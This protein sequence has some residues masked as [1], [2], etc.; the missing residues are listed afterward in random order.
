[1]KLRRDLLTVAMVVLTGS[2]FAQDSTA[3]KSEPTK[4]KP[5]SEVITNKAVSSFGLFAVHKVGD[6]YF[7]EMPDSLLGREL[8]FTTR[9]SKVATG[10]PA[11][12]GEVVNNI[13]VSFEKAEDNKLYVRAN[14][15]VAE[16]AQNQAIA[17]AVNNSTI[18]P[19]IM[20]MDVKARSKSNDGSV[21]DITDFIMKDNLVTGFSSEAK[22]SLRLS[23]VAADRSYFL[24]ANAY[25]Q[26]VEIKTVKTFSMGGAAPAPGEP[27]APTSPSAGVTM[28]M[29]NS[30][31]LLSKTPMNARYADPR[32]GY[33]TES[34]NVFSDAQQKVEVKNFIVRQRL[35]PKSEDLENYKKGVLVEPRNPIVYYVDPATPKQWRQYIIAGINDWNEAFKEAGFKNAIVGK[36]WPENDT[37]MDIDD[38]RWK[39]VRYFPSSNATAY[40]QRLY[41]PRSGEVLQTYIGWSH[42]NMQSLH[43]WYFIQA[44]AADP[45]GRS[46]KFS[47][48]LMGAL[49]RAEISKQVGYSLGLK[50]NLAASSSVPTEKLRDKAWVEANGI[51]PSILDY[52]HYNYV[53]QPSDKIGT[54][55]MVPRIGA[56]DKWAIKYGYT[57]TGISDFEAEKTKVQGWIAKAVNNNPSLRFQAE[58]NI[59]LNDPAD[60]SAQTEDLGD[61]VVLSSQYSLSNMKLLTANLLQWTKEDM[62]MYDNAAIA[63]DNMIDWW[64][65]LNRHVFSQVSGV[66]TSIKS[67]EQEG[68]VYTPISKATQKQAVAYLNREVFQTPTWLLNPTVLNK[69]AKPVKRDKVARFQE[70]AMYQI[71]N[72]NRLY[73][74]YT[75]AMRYSKDKVY[76]V[77]EL[78]TDIRTGVWSELKSPNAVISSNRRGIQK[79]WIENTCMLIRVS[80]T[81]PEAGSAAN[82]LSTTDIPAVVRAQATLVMQQCKTAAATSTDPLTQAHLKYAY[83]KLN[84]ALTGDSKK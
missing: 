84:K 8:L 56:Y 13:N 57:Y 73:R 36:E 71:M 75:Q 46:V 63:Y 23:A 44:A 79:S 82:D 43:D 58:T 51:T 9:F 72:P 83:E 31:M 80:A 21:I 17:R 12:G 30:I 38:A 74:L 69:F 4:L 70:E 77:D 29:S 2:V 7:L 76:S 66:K 19:I 81:A 14:T 55:G 6:K 59:N 32:V 40:A 25:P 26:N 35:E 20:V 33:F 34:F 28:E 39:V 16:V 45:R 15:H 53:A 42:S 64:G 1:M 24:S 65:I 3:K 27:A 37:T 5:Y 47:E 22:K 62:D 67:V 41:D 68:D 60:P 49:I 52:V 10:S 18:D 48:E 54:L 50:T 11:Y 61:N 78:L